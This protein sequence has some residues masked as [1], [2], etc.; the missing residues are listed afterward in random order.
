MIA[1]VKRPVTLARW[2]E[3]R[4]RP[5]S[6]HRGMAQHPPSFFPTSALVRICSFCCSI[7][8]IIDRQPSGPCCSGTRCRSSRR[9]MHAP[10]G[11]AQGQIP[12][13]HCATAGRSRQANMELSPRY[14][15]AG[16][17][18]RALPRC[19]TQHC[20]KRYKLGL[21]FSVVSLVRDV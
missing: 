9:T 3:L 11:P 7:G 21:L 20:R 2:Q 12:S 14:Q 10:V 17:M 13:G 16:G 4:P 18:E 15:G 8:E 6:I 1:R 19:G 5:R